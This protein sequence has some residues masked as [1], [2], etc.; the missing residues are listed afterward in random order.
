[1]RCLINRQRR[2]HN[3]IQF[4]KVCKRY[5]DVVALQN[6]TFGLPQGAM[7]FL[8]G[9]SGAGKSTLLK[10]I[11]L[12]EKPSSGWVTMDNKNLSQLTSLEVALHRRKIGLVF[13]NHHLLDDYT[14]YDN[15][16]LPLKISGY[17]DR[18][19]SKRVKAALAKVGLGEKE[20]Q[21]PKVLSA[22]EQQRIG[23]ARAIVNKPQLILA[24][25]PTG[26]LDPELSSEIMTLF[27]QFNEVGVSVLIASHDLELIN[28]LPHPVLAL[29]QGRIRSISRQPQ[30]HG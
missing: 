6:V 22:G 23:I 17:N 3:M 12:I 14:I 18:D 4:N 20:K 28:R 8:T 24:D 2:L 5:R 29:K 19:A 26:N 11:M 21:Y 30:R 7:A 15:V 16:A 10:L 13:Q 27:Q 25:E 9:H 1:M